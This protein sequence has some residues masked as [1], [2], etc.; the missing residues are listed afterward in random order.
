M[1][2]VNNKDAHIDTRVLF[3]DILLL[4][5]RMSLPLYKLKAF[6]IC[7]LLLFPNP[8]NNFLCS[9]QECGISLHSSTKSLFYMVRINK[10]RI[11]LATRVARSQTLLCTKCHCHR[12]KDLDEPHAIAFLIFDSIGQMGFSFSNPT[13]FNYLNPQTL[14]IKQNMKSN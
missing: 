13:I 3:Y 12:T 11:C 10:H 14:E 9:K 6:V 7:H 2:I 4:Y 1:D 8:R 5:V